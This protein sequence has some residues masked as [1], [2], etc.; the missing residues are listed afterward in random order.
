MNSRGTRRW[1]NRLLWRAMLALGALL[2]FTGSRLIGAPADAGGEAN[3]GQ[4]FSANLS[5]A[6]FSHLGEREQLDYLKAAVL[7]FQKRTSNISFT[8][9]E[10]V[11]NVEFDR[12]ANRIGTRLHVHEGVPQTCDRRTTSVW[13]IGA[14]YRAL[15][16][17]EPTMPKTLTEPM[18]IFVVGF[19]AK[20]GELTCWQGS[21]RDGD[22]PNHGSIVVRSI[23]NDSGPH[24]LFCEYL[25]GGP[26]V[27][28][29]WDLHGWF[30]DGFPNAKISGVDLGSA[31][32][33]VS[34][35][36]PLPQLGR[37]RVVFDL[38][39]QATLV[40]AKIG[41]V[42]G[43]GDGPHKKYGLRVDILNLVLVDGVWLPTQIKAKV[44]D[45]G[46]RAEKTEDYVTIYEDTITF[47]DLGHVAEKDL[48]VEF[49]P[50]T[51]VHDFVRG[52]IYTTGFL[53][54]D[55]SQK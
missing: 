32:V 52:K 14:S 51:E 17:Q 50:D 25:M 47:A 19:D 44:A 12:A 45:S 55:A 7:A 28:P 36:G 40:T 23:D 4:K 27:V 42:P 48:K 13:R 10:V 20:T 53:A 35:A 18:P 43:E 16:T 26:I 31:M 5:V 3:G 6:D 2:V 49:P 9:S 1:R 41:N 29:L 39:R 21:P 37:A 46:K 38:T 33:D 54:P 11:K 8:S 15:V 34:V 24:D 30:L 22:Q